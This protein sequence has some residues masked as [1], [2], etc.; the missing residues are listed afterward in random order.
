MIKI[1]VKEKENVQPV[2]PKIGECFRVLGDRHWNETDVFLRVTDDADNLA[3]IRAVSLKS[4]IIYWFESPEQSFQILDAED[5]HLV[6][7]VRK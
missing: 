4:G 3:V 6:F 2:R 7:V 1:T 5:N